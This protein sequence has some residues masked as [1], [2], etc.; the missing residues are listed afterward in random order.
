[1]FIEDVTHTSFYST[2]RFH[3]YRVILQYFQLTVHER[4]LGFICM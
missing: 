3:N 4:L 2:F 1:M